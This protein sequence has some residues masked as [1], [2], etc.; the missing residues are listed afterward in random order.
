MRASARC[1]VWILGLLAPCFGCSGSSK[2][3]IIETGNACQFNSDCELPLLCTMGTCH[4]TCRISFDCPIGQSCVLPPGGVPVCQLPMESHCVDDSDCALL[5][6][7]IDGLC[8]DE[9]QS[10]MDCTLGRRCT[11]QKVCAEPYQVDVAN[12]LIP[13]D[14]DGGVAADGGIDVAIGSPDA[15]E[16]AF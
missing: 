11:Q 5:K 10:S 3:T 6:C 13:A 7:A 12:N 16:T 1:L 4:E 2:K 15:P 14:V 9:C 8:H